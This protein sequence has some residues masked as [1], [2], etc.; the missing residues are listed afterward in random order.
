MPQDVNHW[1][2]YTDPNPQRRWTSNRTA[3]ALFGVTIRD[4]PDYPCGG[5]FPCSPSGFVP[6]QL[7]LMSMHLV[8]GK[9]LIGLPSEVNKEL[10]RHHI[11]GF[12]TVTTEGLMAPVVLS[13]PDGWGG[14][15]FV[16]VGFWTIHD[17]EE[18]AD[19]RK[20][21]GRGLMFAVN[22]IT[23]PGWIEGVFNSM[24]PVCGCLE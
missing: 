5:P 23:L 16:S 12:T 17:M 19:L 10:G 15:V 1:Q 3:L 14:D 8:R 21:V 6:G 18:P 24:K 22:T 20:F 13:A 4:E 2:D 11:G 9:E 7:E